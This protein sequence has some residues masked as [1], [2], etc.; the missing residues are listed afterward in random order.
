MLNSK[1][2]FLNLTTRCNLKCAKCWRSQVWGKGQDIDKDVLDKFLNV[3]ANYE[4]TIIVGSGENLI[5]QYLDT[6]IDW[7]V[8]N[9]IKTTILTTALKFDKFIDKPEYF[10]P[11]IEWGVTMDGFQDGQLAPI[12]KGMKIERVKENLRCIKNRYPDASFYINYTHTTINLKDTIPMIH[13]ASELGIKSF[14]IT[15]L[16]LFEG[17]D[18]S[19]TKHLVND[20]NSEEFRVTMQ[21]A[22]ATTK[23]M[24]IKFYAPESQKRKLCFDSH[25]TNHSPIID[26]NG[27][28]SFCY[29]RDDTI[30]GN[31]LDDDGH[32]IWQQH[33]DDLNTNQSRQQ[34]W[35]SQC[36]ASKTNEN[37]YFIIPKKKA[38]EFFKQNSSLSKCL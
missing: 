12:Q 24:G 37:G 31:L 3:F 2:I 22:H 27:D 21:E 8:D 13:F 10:K 23:N 19:I 28:I 32:T 5:C 4:G 36:Y 1:T 26:V 18:D 35:C 34:A 30:I 7:V 25:R 15:Q 14:Y 29:G 6:F 9:N 38:S 20:I 11:N 17:L 33:L 16:K